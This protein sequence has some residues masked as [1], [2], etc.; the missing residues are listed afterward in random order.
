MSALGITLIVLGSLILLYILITSFLA[1]IAIKKVFKREKWPKRTFL[2]HYTD[3]DFDFP[4]KE[5]KFKSGKNTLQGYLYGEN[6]KKGLVIY[7]CGLSIEHSSYISEVI[8]LVNRGYKVFTYDFTGTG[9]SEGDKQISVHIQAVDA[10][11]CLTFIENNPD[12]KGENIFLY[13]HSMGAYGVAV[14]SNTHHHVKAIA[15]ISGFY[16]PVKCLVDVTKTKSKVLAFFLHP[17]FFFFQLCHYGKV[18][19][20]NA[21]KDLKETNIP[22]FIVHGTNDE[23]VNFKTTSIISK[24]DKIK[25]PKV[26]YKVMD[27]PLH[28]S[29]TSVI[30][31]TEAVKYQIEK[32]NKLKELMKTHSKDDSMDIILKDFVKKRFNQ[33]NQNLMEEIDNFFQS[34]VD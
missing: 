9:A 25:N 21:I 29:H 32:K 23:M 7:V 22:T 11:N 13:G 4:R 24:K 8:A 31:S 20:R 30:A 2:M 34:N 10:S 1:S 3:L 15:S 14:N 26:T 19:I 16:S 17:N 12:F 28:S 18:G 5:Y 6:N 27:D 33:A